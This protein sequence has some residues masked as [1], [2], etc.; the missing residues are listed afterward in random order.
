VTQPL[1][2]SVGPTYADANQ[3]TFIPF[4]PDQQRKLRT[5]GGNSGALIKSFLPHGVTLDHVGN[6]GMWVRST[7]GQY[8][9]MDRPSVAESTTQIAANQKAQADAKAK[10]DQAFQ[11]QHAWVDGHYVTLTPVIDPTTGRVTAY[12]A[13]PVGGSG[14]QQ[15]AVPS[16]FGA[17]DGSQIDETSPF[18]MSHF[19]LGKTSTP[20]ATGDKAK[21]VFGNIFGAVHQ[22]ATGGVGI[23]TIG[24][25][26]N[27]LASLST[28]DPVAYQAML[29]KLHAA[30][31]LND[32]DY[33]SAGGHWSAAAGQA[34]MLA[35]R[36]VS[37]IN[38]TDGGKD[39]TL[40][41]F[42]TSKATGVGQAT[43]D[44]YKPAS[45]NY[46]DPETVKAVAKD[47]AEKVLGRRLSDTE[48]AELTTHFRSL[49]DAAYDQVDAAGRAGNGGARFTPPDTSGQADAYV[50]SG[51]REQEA[52]NWSAA[53][54]L[55]VIKS[56][57][58]Q[59]TRLT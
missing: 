15:L 38:A 2:P 53:G 54:Y 27:W 31:Y 43:A 6:G 13:S 33:V 19:Q 25:G 11:T 45:R 4:T 56:L 18:L 35:A 48:E 42:L 30:G 23:M 36:D 57:F 44:T 3:L 46:T 41:E 49:E 37:A 5:A 52:A 40:E 26:V 58:S 12:T 14:S 7:S 21:G 16:A 28:K 51:P 1:G 22:A 34:F 50:D 17:I 8:Q 29:D 32:G 10:V 39:T 20:G 24:N 55:D 9:P 47:A 59:T